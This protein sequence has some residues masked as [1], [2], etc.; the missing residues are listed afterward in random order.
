MCALF[1]DKLHTGSLHGSTCMVYVRYATACKWWLQLAERA[2]IINRRGTVHFTAGAHSTDPTATPHKSGRMFIVAEYSRKRLWQVVMKYLT[3][4]GIIG[5]CI[6][7]RPSFNWIT[8]FGNSILIGATILTSCNYH[9]IPLAFFIGYPKESG[10][11]QVRS[12]NS[13]SVT[14]RELHTATTWLWVKCDAMPPHSMTK[15]KWCLVSPIW[16]T[17]TDLDWSEIGNKIW[18]IWY[19][20]QHSA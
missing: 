3:R 15:I 18:K 7:H 6:L 20:L 10:G 12:G 2:T 11:S 13:R 1:C 9:L 17:W 14:G 16:L 19:T 5:C 4:T 8:H